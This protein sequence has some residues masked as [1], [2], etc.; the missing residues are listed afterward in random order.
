MSLDEVPV[1]ASIGSNTKENKT[2]THGRARDRRYT[3]QRASWELKGEVPS[4][5]RR[6]EM[7]YEGLPGSKD[8]CQAPKAPSLSRLQGGLPEK[9]TDADAG[10]LLA[11]GHCYLIGPECGLVSDISQMPG[12]PNEYIYFN[13][14][15]SAV[16]LQIG[17]TCSVFLTT[18]YTMPGS[19]LWRLDLIGQSTAKN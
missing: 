11:L 5:W 12:E 1:C 6:E 2:V 9:L 7:P 14:S 3:V 17:I 18:P 13:P 10:V 8:L 4:P 16:S 15:L 19:Q